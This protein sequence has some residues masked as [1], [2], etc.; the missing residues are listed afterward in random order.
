MIVR[1]TDLQAARRAARRAW[2][3]FVLPACAA[4]TAPALLA[5]LVAADTALDAVLTIPYGEVPTVSGRLRAAERSFSDYTALRAARRLR[6]RA[7][8]EVGFQ[9]CWKA[10]APAIAAYARALLDHGVDLRRLDDPELCLIAH[11]AI[12]SA[13]AA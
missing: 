10:C 3:T 4:R 6:H 12:P 8:H 2:Q 13:L 9:L 7:V 5:A 11:E 1:P